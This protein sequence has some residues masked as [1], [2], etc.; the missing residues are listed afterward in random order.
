M[1][2]KIICEVNETKQINRILGKIYRFLLNSK[3]VLPL[4]TIG[5]YGGSLLFLLFMYKNSYEEHYM[6]ELQ[7]R[8]Q[9]VCSNLG[10]VK[11]DSFCNG[12]A[13]I[14]WLLRYLHAEGVIECDDI[15][16]LLH[17]LDKRLFDNILNNNT[18]DDFLH[19][20]LGIAYYFLCYNSCY[21]EKVVSHYLSSLNERK[22][23]EA[24]N[25]FKWLSNNLSLENKIEKAYN[26]GMAHGMASLVGF[27]S[28]CITSK[29]QEMKASLLL[30][31]LIN[32]YMNC[33]NPEYLGSMFSFW[34]Y[35]DKNGYQ[36]TRLAWC[37]G[38]LGIAS[39]IYQAGKATSNEKIKNFALNIFDS[40]LS[41][42]GRNEDTVE[43]SSFCHGSAG[44]SVIYNTIY[45]E[46][47]LDKYKKAALYWIDDTI[48][49]S[50]KGGIYAGYELPHINL[51]GEE[52]SSNVLSLINGLS[53]IG[54]TLLS[55]ISDDIPTWKKCFML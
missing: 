28:T 46:T 42:I 33:I 52:N 17:D 13:G 32:Y 53:G 24:C 10:Y 38:D 29:C 51:E 36:R 8:I 49:K 2:N 16:S 40:T 31:G 39:A 35:P 37:Y 9:I 43:E 22:I 26:L 3:G 15:N 54:L 48:Q 11:L 23:D 44:L 14:C 27:L 21:S 6:D 18:N 55:S 12:L 50:Y 45:Q 1:W 30:D 47:H 5:G 25:I 41:R 34:L 7:R 19:G 4:G 20:S